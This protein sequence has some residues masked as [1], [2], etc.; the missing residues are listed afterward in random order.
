MVGDGAVSQG[1]CGNQNSGAPRHRRGVVL[2]TVSARWRGDNLT[3][4]MISTQVSYRVG[5]DDVS[6]A[7]LAARQ[8]YFQYEGY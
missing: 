4:W 7:Q 3:H 5:A 8:G 1:L 2:V 6:R